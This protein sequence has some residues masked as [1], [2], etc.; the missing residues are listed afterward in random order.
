MAGST[1]RLRADCANCF[2]LC[3]VAPAFTRSSDFAIDKPAGTP[4]PN[5][6]ADFGCGIHDGLRDRGFPGCTVFDCFGAGQQVA[7]V[8]FGGRDWR[9]TPELAQPMFQA[10]AVMRQVHELLWYLTE[11]QRLADDPDELKAAIKETERLTTLDAD[12]LVALDLDG[13]RATANTL[14]LRVSEQVRAG[15][16]GC[17]LRGADLVGKRMTKLR[18]ANLRG[19]YLIGADLRRADLGLA[20]VTG[21]DLRGANLAAA[22][23]TT[24]IFLTQAQL[25]AAQGDAATGLP[26]ALRRPAHWNG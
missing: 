11:A 15:T 10:F 2:G 12:A 24:T 7:Q 8:T 18:G 23:L 1:T 19:A 5:L 14:L 13:H 9:S 17:E 20:D 4:C 21:A 16:G 6:L 26:P 25:D 22:D 3:C